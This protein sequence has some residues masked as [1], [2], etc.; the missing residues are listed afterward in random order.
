MH[1]E[2]WKDEPIEF[3]AVHLSE[4]QWKVVKEV[5]HRF[6]Y[7]GSASVWGYVTY[8]YFI[9]Y[10]SVDGTGF[11]FN[12]R[13]L[14]YNGS[15]RNIDKVHSEESYFQQSTVHDFLDLTLE[16]ILVLKEI[17]EFILGEMP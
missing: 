4:D 14:F 12:C 5:I 2:S 13:N 3:K 1:N 17:Y 16:E 9:K 11:S 7:E 6:K 8:D 15:R 10:C